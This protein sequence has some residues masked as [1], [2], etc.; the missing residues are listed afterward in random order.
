MLLFFGGINNVEFMARLIRLA[1][2]IGWLAPALCAVKLLSSGTE[3]HRART[4]QPATHTVEYRCSTPT[5]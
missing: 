1:T 5:R 2:F 4:E 3:L